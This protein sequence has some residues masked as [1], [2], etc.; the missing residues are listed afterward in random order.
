MLGA[1]WNTASLFYLTESEMADRT[2]CTMASPVETDDGV[3]W[4]EYRDLVYRN[5]AYQAVVHL[6]EKGLATRGIVGCGD[7][8]LF[9]AKAAVTET[10]PGRR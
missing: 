8:V 10:L 1:P 9:D 2:E 5:I 3:K 4:V 7:S 6:V